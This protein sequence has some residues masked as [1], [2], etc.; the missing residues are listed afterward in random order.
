MAID[1]AA[2]ERAIELAWQLKTK[3]EQYYGEPSR[4]ERHAEI[5][6]IQGEIEK[7]GI[8]VIKE[9]GAKMVLGKLVITADVTLY[10]RNDA[11]CH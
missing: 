7:L 10:K 1:Q 11:L 9:L 4:L 8:L 3:M 5:R 2:Q 6:A